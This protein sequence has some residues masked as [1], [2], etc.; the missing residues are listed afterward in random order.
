M[1]E[2]KPLRHMAC[3]FHDATES[4]VMKRIEAFQACGSDVTGFTFRR[5]RNKRTRPPFWRNIDLGVTEERNY[6]KRL[7]K[8]GAGLL[9]ALTHWRTLR[10]ARVFYARNIDM[11]IIAVLARALTASRG[12]VVYEVLDIQRVFLGGGRINTAV[13]WAERILLKHT[14]LLVVSSPDFMSRYF[15]PVQGYAGAWHLLENKVSGGT[16]LSEALSASK[17]PQPPPPPWIIGWFGVLRCRRS[18]EVLALIA[19]KLGDKVSIQLRGITSE[20]D[21]TLAEIEARCA[22]RR[23]MSYLGPYLNPEDLPTIYGAVH[24]AWS[25]DY[26]D[27]GTN[28]DWLLPN[29][30]YEAGL[31]GVPALTRAGT[32]TARKA[33]AERLGWSFAEP[34][35]QTVTQFLATLETDTYDAMRQSVS[36]K[37]RSTFVD[38]GDTRAMLQRIDALAA[39]AST[40]TSGA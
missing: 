14:Q 40:F 5:L 13:R 37:D 17:A 9:K 7:P 11:L 6:L 29:R 33:T 2:M 28:S 25:I 24:F 18:L 10:Q 36:G 35:D 31:F 20:D 39:G 3:F 26:L 32:A 12:A 30:I 1:T 15:V 22:E 38:T 19:E 8:L 4:T 23:N 27:A 34:L 21:L 16:R